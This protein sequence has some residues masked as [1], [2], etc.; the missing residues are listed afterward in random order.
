MK[1]VDFGKVKVQ[2]TFEGNPVEFNMR[3][4]IGNMIRQN[5]NDIGLDEF[6]R[7]VY[8]SDGPVEIPDEYIK[9]I[10][11]IVNLSMT[12]PAQKALNELLT[13]E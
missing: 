4:V 7:K 3:K 2:L 11:G 12:V 8:F 10:L 5:T 6:A 9:P 13:N 1:Q